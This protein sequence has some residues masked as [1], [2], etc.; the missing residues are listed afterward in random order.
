MKIFRQILFAIFLFAIALV[1]IQ[2]QPTTKAAP[3]SGHDSV[4]AGKVAVVDTRLFYDQ[5]S[6]IQKLI[7]AYKQLETEFAATQA[8]LQAMQN[9]IVAMNN[10]IN[11]LG[12]TPAAKAKEEELVRLQRDFSYKHQEAEAAFNKRRMILVQPIQTHIG[13]ALQEFITT[14]GITLLLDASKLEGAIL[15]ALPT[16]DVTQAFI[17]DYNLKHPGSAN[18]ASR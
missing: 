4:P 1:T 14:R 6:G 13:K 8:A 11:K 15:A 7:R 17:A 5:N 16:T 9:R 3:S 2:A 10:E 12:T 18:A